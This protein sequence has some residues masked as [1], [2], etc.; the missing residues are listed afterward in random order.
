MIDLDRS[1]SLSPTNE[2]EWRAFADPA[3]EANTGMFGGWT[4]ALMLKAAIEAGGDYTPAAITVS[5]ARRIEAGATINVRARPIVSGRSIAQWRVEIT[6]VD[7]EVM[8]SAAVVSARRRENDRFVEGVAPHAPAPS[9]FQE[10]HPPGPFGASVD[11]RPVSGFPPLNQADTRTLSW[12][13]D[14]SGAPLDRVRLGFLADVAPP[15]IWLVGERPRPS[16]TITMSV[17]FY[18]NEEELAAV[19][20]DYILSEVTGVRAE[21]S[22]YG[23]AMRLWSPSGALLATS[24]QLCWFK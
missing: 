20:S 18:A 8:A 22:V 24:E 2:N 14:L 6:G 11:V 17:Y 21:G 13:R 16:S 5:F 3:F 12:V 4:A 19:G 23:H 15:R 7:G 9:E 10:F 1:L